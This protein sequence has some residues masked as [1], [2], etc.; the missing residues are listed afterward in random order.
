MLAVPSVGMAVSTNTHNVD[1]GVLCDWIEASVLFLDEAHLSDTV[2]VDILKEEEIYRSQEFAWEIVEEA[3]SQLEDRQKWIGKASPI[4]V[5]S[6]RLIRHRDWQQAPAHSFYLALTLAG[7]Y[8]K[9]ARRFGRNF[10]V[11]GELF[12]KLTKESVELLFP[13]WVVY[14]TGWARTHA[15]KIP[16]IV[17]E[18]ANLLSESK[19][20]IK[21]WVGLHANEAGLDLLCYRPFPDG[22]VGIPVYLM[23]CASGADWVEKLHTPNIEIWR[24]I[25][26]FAARPGK[27]FAMP[28]ALTHDEFPSKCLAVNGL[29]LDRYR[30]LSSGRDN[31]DW[32]PADLTHDIVAW[33]EPRLA[34]LPQ[35]SE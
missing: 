33:L 18:V 1:V 30:L 32:V 3:W 7:F 14:P 9:W 13:G 20:D 16:A 35:Y 23:Q 19:G 28:F 22:R 6:L 8:P 21:R 11:Q 31:P 27:A 5:E 29:T 26:Q 34:T 12:E 10:T 15:K 2:V 4:T 17:E 25:V 24:Q